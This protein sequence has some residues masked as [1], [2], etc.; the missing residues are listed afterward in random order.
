MTER[1]I[2]GSLFAESY[3]EESIR[4]LPEWNQI[5]DKEIEEIESWLRKLLPLPSDGAASPNEAE[6]EDE[7]I[8]P[9]LRRLGWTEHLRQQNLSASGRMDV[10]DFLLFADEASKELAVGSP[11]EWKRYE[12]G[13]AIIEAKRWARPLDRRSDG[14]GEIL[15]PS[16]QMLRYVRRADDVTEGRLRWGIL[17]N[18]CR[19]RLYFAGARSVSEQFFEIDLAAILSGNEEDAEEAGRR[20]WLKVFALVFQRR[21]FLADA[22]GRTFHRRVIELGKFEQERVSDN[23]SGLVFDTVFPRLAE[24]IAEKAPEVPTEEIR[25][26]VLFLLYRLLFILYAEDR[27]LLPVRHRRYRDY[28]FRNRVRLDV[29]RRKD[30]GSVFSRTATSYWSVILG[31]CRL[32]DEGDEDIGL[33]PYDGGLFERDSAPLLDDIELS[34]AVMADVID[35]LSFEETELGR[36]YINYRDLGVQQLGSIYERLLEQELVRE[37]GRIAVRPS[38][39]SRKDS[40]SYYTPDELVELIISETLGP[41]AQARIDRFQNAAGTGAE[42]RELRQ[43]DPAIALLDLK[44]CDPAM[45]S[46]HFLV[47][48]VDYLS[49]RVI[50]AMAASGSIAPGYVSPLAVR[51]E[52]I[53]GTISGN[54]ADSNWFVEPDQL[55]DRHI[56]RRMVLKRCVYGVDKNP[57]AVE[58]AKVSLWLHTFTV[59]A[60]LS[61]LDHH[62]RCG[63]SLFG[64]WVAKARADAEDEGGAIFLNEPIRHAMDSAREMQDI[65]ALTDAEIAE[66]HRSEELFRSVSTRTAPLNA[67]LSTLL[68]FDWMN[69]PRKSDERQA[70]RAWLEGGYGDPIGVANGTV[71]V[72]PDAEETGSANQRRKTR[73]RKLRFLGLLDRARH[74]ISEMRFLHWQVAFPGVWPDWAGDNRDGG[75]DAV[76][77]NPPWDKMKLQQVEWFSARRPEIARAATGAERR[78]MIAELRGTGEPLADEYDRAAGMSETARRMARNCGDYPLL[79]GGDV[80]L[81]SLFVERSMSL[82]KP[83]GMVGLLVPSGIASD[84]TA[85]RFFGSVAT[86]GRLKALLDFE[87]RRLRFG[88]RPFFPD[89]DGR[90]KFCVFAASP[91]PVDGQSNCGFFLHDASE[92]EDPDRCFPLSAED[93]ASVNPNTGTAPIFRTRRDADLVTAIYGRLPVLVD[94]SGD[95]AVETWP[96]KYSRMFDM[97]ND[98]GL[99]RTRTQ[100]EEDE[101]AWAIVGN[102]FDSP[103]GIWVPLYVGRMIHQYDHRAASVE[104]NEGNLHNQALSGDIGP[105]LKSDPLFSPTP[106]YWVREESVLLPDETGWILGFRDIARATDARTVIAAIAP[107]VGFGNKLPI[108]IPY[109]EDRR[110]WLLAGNLNSAVLNYVARQKIHSTSLNLFILEQLPVVPPEAYE[111]VRFG[112]KPAAE[113]VREA[114]LELTYTAYDMA[115]FARDLGHV[116]DDG[117]ILPPF[118]WD[119]ERRLRLRAKLDALYFYL[120][121][122]TDRDDVRYIYSTFPIVE[123]QETEAWGGY[124][125]RDLCLAWMNALEGGRPD[126]DIRPPAYDR[127]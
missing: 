46:G 119:E 8:L 18:G 56:I 103:A 117:E 107:A 95:R 15:A 114:V 99:F 40:G 93:F 105:D 3:L 33:P 101:R 5:T 32:I 71:A 121:G 17:T 34:D 104:L 87:N 102:R 1:P 85:A 4:E 90:F 11:D 73:V 55:D 123:R 125:T 54:A 10:P 120:Y 25:N 52:S 31:L 127:P 13:V 29:G 14:S 97:T 110:E 78:R 100:L 30:G 91:S 26:A 72:D 111:E 108:L 63:D 45:G 58:L 126:A 50:E 69:L 47:H 116:D 96:V 65:E 38:V 75:F 88:T 98:S 35:A 76:I 24:A 89:V 118:A 16:S 6:T 83:D 22:E 59:G 57:M 80:N 106:Q 113:I 61:Y 66:A 109:A 92:V 51:I 41:L 19:W 42:A 20:H 23:L 86:E 12:H 28:A 74:L 115:P 122:V 7:I 70:V 60:P 48:L 21:A 9:V 67:F 62:L 43:Q 81:Y 79:S 84:K 64:S 44:V 112:P 36:R 27:D 2:G 37:D 49:D 94:R 124:L 68:A 39:Y 53:R 82:A 77:G